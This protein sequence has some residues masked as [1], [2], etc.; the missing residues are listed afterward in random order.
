MDPMGLMLRSVSTRQV[1]REEETM[2]CGA[3]TEPSYHT[4]WKKFLSDAA[5]LWKSYA[6]QFADQEKKLA[7]EGLI[8][9]KEGLENAKVDA[10]EVH[11][12]ASDDDLPVQGWITYCSQTHRDNLGWVKV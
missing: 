9:A 4:A 11:Q 2:P 10:G 7:R 8:L 1:L 12:V 5:Q 3:G 6:A